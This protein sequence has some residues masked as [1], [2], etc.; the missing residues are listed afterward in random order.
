[1]NS[2]KVR[3]FDDWFGATTGQVVQSGLSQTRRLS[4][5]TGVAALL[6]LALAPET[7]VGDRLALTALVALALG[8]AIAWLQLIPQRQRP[9][10]ASGGVEN[11]SP[12][13]WLVTAIGLAF[14][15]GL[16]VQ[17]WFRPGTGIAGGDIPPPQG[18][19]WLGKLFD[20]WIWSGSSLGE[21]SQ[22][23][24]ELPWAEVLASV[25]ALGGDPDFAQRIWYTLIFVGAALSAFALLAALRMGPVAALVGSVVYLLNP[26]VVSEVN[27]YD[28]FMV[29]LG[30]L[31]AMP[32][33]LVA[34]GS[35]RISVGWGA[36]LL[37]LASP[38]LGYA[39]FNPPLVG[40]VL[41]VLL[42]TPLL[43]A[44]IDGKEAGWRSVR[45]L[46][47]AIPLLLATSAYW[48]YPAMLHLSDFSGSQ[49]VSLSTW[50]WTE[51]RATIGNA[52]WLN[53]TWGWRTLAYYPYAPAYDQLPLRIAE[54]SMPAIAFSALG[55]RV[56]TGVNQE[57]HNH[58][59]LRLAVAGA[60]IA[61]IVIFISTGTNPP[62][63]TIFNLIYKLPFGW[64]LREPGRFL[65]MVALAYSLL[66]AALVQA[67]TGRQWLLA[68]TKWRRP[69]AYMFRL[70]IV[71]LTLAMCLIVGFPLYTGAIVPDARP[72][73]PPVHV[74]V[75]AYWTQMGHVVDSL[76]VQGG[77]LVMP[78]DDFYQMPYDWGYYGTDSFVVHMF[79][80]PVLIPNGQGYS[81]ASS[82]I[83][84]AVNL[85]ASSIVGRDWRHVESLVRALNAPLILVRRDVQPG[86]LGRSI[87]P[88]DD[89]SAALRAAPNFE[90]I[91]QI[92]AL[93]LF[94]MVGQTSD[95][96]LGAS[97]ATI[98][99]Q[100]PDLRI[101]DLTPPNQALVTSESQ[102]GVP[103]I[104]QA[105]PVELWDTKGGLLVWSPKS[106]P[107]WKYRIGDLDSKTVIA[108]D[109]PG[110]LRTASSSTRVEYAP[111]ATNVVTVS[112]P[113]QSVVIPNGDFASGQWGHVEDCRGVNREQA[114]LGAKVV[115][116]SAPGAYAALQMRATFDTACES[117]LF[118]PTDPV[119][120]WHNKSLVVSLMVHAIRGDP[121]RICLREL[122]R[123][124][125]AIGC[126]SVPAIPD[127]RGWSTF[128]A[129]FTPG[130]GTTKIRLYLYA[131]GSPS[132]SQTIV[133][134]ANVQV[135][136]VPALPAL[137]LLSDPM[138]QQTPSLQLALVHTS[139]SS[140]W[141][142]SVSGRH[143]IVDGMLN[144]WL[145]SPSVEKFSATYEPA[146]KF[147]AAQWISLIG[148]L[149]ALALPVWPAA[150]RLARRYLASRSGRL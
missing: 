52:F 80:R 132:E 84:Q 46:L 125:D 129:S 6:C 60:T 54:F 117:Q 96:A 18:T 120:G 136:E 127:Q 91:R 57:L 30:L 134:Y 89:L 61:L 10:V 97:F 122:L 45:A 38:L 66:C 101:L 40:L 62:G 77:L 142:P 106:P 141:Q 4:V 109:R 22:L 43:V 8:T 81:P 50:V 112:L 36:A 103:A 113:T 64:L 130:N 105:P 133:E 69:S 35:G 85:T 79:Q 107:G 108:L 15:A 144:G 116:D 14:V 13:A 126:A 24:G 53:A 140:M 114:R 121:P 11:W 100:T 98:N 118:V 72:D 143:V 7:G 17:T 111:D 86:F 70:G 56:W 71:P 128:R 5:A 47:L 41:G 87:V 32:A 48:I 3:W 12:R 110:S 104:V 145:I 124:G 138:G 93:D 90:L 67:L 44:W 59:E 29:A 148:A 92:G 58:R 83:M 73:L 55:L 146:G 123:N 19:A 21:P 131:D 74:K 75:P 65:M 26:Y 1:M 42:A 119:V 63:N 102:P 28:V 2:L 31:A 78:P 68:F 135:L 76:P 25:H 94:S 147:R 49:L 115:A 37:A 33:A 82:Q 139:F 95:V 149:L 99:T 16:A 9:F 27:T 88:P 137:V 23:Q 150:I 51:G 34:V 39:F 20:P